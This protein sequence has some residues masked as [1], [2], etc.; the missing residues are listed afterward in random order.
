MLIAGLIFCG[1]IVALFAY[2]VWP[3]RIDRIPIWFW[4]LW[5]LS[6]GGSGAI[7]YLIVRLILAATAY[8]S[9]HTPSN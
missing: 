8:Y 1:L 6:L 5:L 4:I 3:D 7:I 9:H 2:L